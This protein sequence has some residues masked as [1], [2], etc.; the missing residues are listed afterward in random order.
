MP[1]YPDKDKWGT[2]D[3]KGGSCPTCGRTYSAEEQVK[4]GTE[5]KKPVEWYMK[6][7]GDDVSKWPYD[8]DKGKK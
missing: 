4:G 7:Y 2:T 1:D 6:N 5:Y 3:L 8:P